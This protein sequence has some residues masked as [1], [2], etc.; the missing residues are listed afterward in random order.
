[1]DLTIPFNKIVIDILKEFDICLDVIKIILNYHP[2]N[3]SLEN[4]SIIKISY[5]VITESGSTKYK[6]CQ[7]KLSQKDSVYCIPATGPIHLLN[8]VYINKL[9]KKLFQE[10]NTIF[11][12][13]DKHQNN[14]QINN[15]NNSEIK[16]DDE[17]K[18]KNETTNELN[19]YVSII[20]I[21]Y[22]LKIQHLN[23]IWQFDLNKYKNDSY[24]YSDDK[25]WCIE[26]GFID[27][28]HINI[29]YNEPDE[30]MT[31]AAHLIKL[32]E[33]KTE[34]QS[35]INNFNNRLKYY[36]QEITKIQENLY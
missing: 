10:N 3:Q 13:E 14:D 11:N 26:L 2:I 16:N 15:E 7:Y 32:N 31:F 22:P 35:T 5:N 12:N 4:L 24:L 34:L 18:N 17:S 30:I 23:K 25:I 27:R 20:D 36:E 6:I 19:N 8:S 28:S 1:M 9:F 33:F 21:R 29:I